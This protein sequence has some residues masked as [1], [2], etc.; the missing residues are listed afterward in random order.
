MIP[1]AGRDPSRCKEVI[2]LNEHNYRRW[3]VFIAAGTLL[4][5][6]IRLWIGG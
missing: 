5:A 6:V 3:V 2:E 1:L 4:V